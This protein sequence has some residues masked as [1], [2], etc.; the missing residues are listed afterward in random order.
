MTVGRTGRICRELDAALRKTLSSSLETSSAFSLMSS[1]N[2]EDEEAIPGQITYGRI[3]RLYE[4]LYRRPLEMIHPIPCGHTWKTVPGVTGRESMGGQWPIVIQPAPPPLFLSRPSE[5]PKLDSPKPIIIRQGPNPSVENQLHLA[6][7]RRKIRVIHRER[8]D[9]QKIYPIGP[10]REVEYFPR[11]IRVIDSS[12]SGSEAI[13]VE[14]SKDNGEGP[15]NARRVIIHR[16]DGTI[17][18]G[19]DEMYYGPSIVHKSSE[20][21]D[22]LIEAIAANFLELRRKN[23]RTTLEPDRRHIARYTTLGAPVSEVLVAARTP[24]TE[25]VEDRSSL[26]S[27]GSLSPVERSHVVVRFMRNLWSR[28]RSSS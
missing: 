15:S 27:A 24:Y 28:V 7:Y 16:E 12:D 2:S 19:G 13:S 10:T 23:V 4:N 3:E 21:R 26:I 20:T 6:E 9:E 22:M 1:P 5:N 17:D 8:T 11:N 18:D 25:M 14:P